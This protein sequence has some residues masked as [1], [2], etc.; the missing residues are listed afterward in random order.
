MAAGG[1]ESAPAAQ[2]APSAV[3]ERWFVRAIAAL[4]T[5]SRL[6]LRLRAG[7]DQRGSTDPNT[8][9]AERVHAGMPGHQRGEKADGG[10]RVGA[11]DGPVHAAGRAGASPERQC[12]EFTAGAVRT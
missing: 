12:S 1:A 10:G 3:T 9:G 4:A 5:Q 2:T 6:E 7:V 11:A 8:D